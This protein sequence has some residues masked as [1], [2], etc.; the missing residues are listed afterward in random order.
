[1]RR[2]QRSSGATS[3]VASTTG[4][5]TTDLPD[6]RGLRRSAD[7]LLAAIT[8]WIPDQGRANHTA[9]AAGRGHPEHPQA[10]R[11]QVC[12]AE[13][14]APHNARRRDQESTPQGVQNAGRDRVMRVPGE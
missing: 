13:H 9:D 11:R 3:P 10:H 4:I 8:P 7:F 14:H 6:I 5:A 2:T 12:R 1:M